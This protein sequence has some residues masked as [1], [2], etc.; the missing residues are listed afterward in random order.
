MD[1]QALEPDP[2]PGV[3]G[4]TGL[5]ITQHDHNQLEA[6]SHQQV[7]LLLVKAHWAEANDEESWE[8]AAG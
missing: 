1:N 4:L 2:G 6:G 5:P 7:I 8:G 3:P